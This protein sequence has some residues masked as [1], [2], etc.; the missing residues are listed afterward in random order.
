VLTKLLPPVVKELSKSSF[1]L[2]FG[3]EDFLLH[4]VAQ[5]V[6]Q[7]AQVAD[8]GE[9]YGG[10]AANLQRSAGIWFVSSYYLWQGGPAFIERSD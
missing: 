4:K 2:L 10:C 5:E 1:S 6:K 9:N 7:S 8:R 3:K